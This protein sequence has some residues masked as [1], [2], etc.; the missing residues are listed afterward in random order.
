MHKYIKDGIAIHHIETDRPREIVIFWLTGNN[1]E[2]YHK[3]G[4][5]S[6]LLR[7]AQYLK[8]PSLDWKIKA[9]RPVKGWNKY[10]MRNSHYITH[11]YQSTTTQTLKTRPSS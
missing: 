2:S 5:P 3:N 8:W 9:D 1:Q 7:P 11:L 6:F 10:L 4:F